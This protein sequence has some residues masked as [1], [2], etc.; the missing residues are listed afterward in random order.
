MSAKVTKHITF[1]APLAE[2]AMR[3]ASIYGVSFGEYLRHLI[4]QAKS[5]DLKIE[6]QKRKKWEDSLPVYE[7]TEAEEKSIKQ[8]IEDIRS[9]DYTTLKSD[10]SRKASEL[11]NIN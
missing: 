5:P 2:K 7:A 1:P 11:L 4:M 9:G 3:H 8:G 6:E 10:D